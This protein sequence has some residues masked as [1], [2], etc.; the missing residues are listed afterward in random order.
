M[1]L[2]LWDGHFDTVVL[3]AARVLG[4]GELTKECR[5]GTGQNRDDRPAKLHAPE[6]FGSWFVVWRSTRPRLGGGS[7]ILRLGSLAAEAQERVRR[8]AGRP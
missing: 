2:S 6:Q 8:S 7:S 5:A 1:L 3:L 4:S